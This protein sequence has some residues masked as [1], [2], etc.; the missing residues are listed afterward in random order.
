MST[1]ILDHLPQLRPHSNIQL[2]NDVPDRFKSR[3]GRSGQHP[4]EL[5][6]PVLVANA[7]WASKPYKGIQSLI[8]VKKQTV[9]S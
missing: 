6:E 3:M 2:V 9:Y 5:I 8:Q 7:S 1:E 4:K